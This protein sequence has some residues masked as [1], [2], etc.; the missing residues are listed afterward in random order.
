[1]IIEYGI[2]TVGKSHIK[3]GTCCQDAHYIL[4]L[5]NGWVIAAVADGVGSEKNSD[6]GSRIA[7][8]TVVKFCEECMPWDYNVINIKSMIRTAY[9]YAFKQILKEAEQSGET[10]E[11]YDTTLSLVIYDGQRIVYGHSG[12]GAILGL[13]TSGEYIAITRPQ[14]SVDGFSVIPLRAGYEQWVIDSYDEDLVAV[15]L[16]TDGML[17]TLCN[18][19]LFDHEREIERAY[20]PLVSYFA[21]PNGFADNSVERNREEITSFVVADEQYNSLDFYNR[22]LKIYKKHLPEKAETI[23]NSFKKNNYPVGMMQLQQDDKTIVGLINTELSF[24]DKD[25]AYYSEPD[26]SGLQEAW[27][28][29]AYPH[30]YVKS[31]IERG[32]DADNNTIG[33][34]ETIAI[35]VV[36]SNVV[37]ESDDDEKEVG[38]DDI[39]DV[40]VQTEMQKIISSENKSV[41]G[42][43]NELSTSESS[44]QVC[45]EQRKSKKKRFL[46][47]MDNLLS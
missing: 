22:L 19:L 4:K 1:M 37:N 14:K 46:E 41:K 2:S 33:D 12:D 30:L 23:V 16:M 15:L 18:P 6:I 20:V 45:T 9:N 25:E 28:R 39:L 11:S 34:D 38:A 40:E 26:W 10:I 3:S 32:T 35:D 43:K 27:N 31:T 44:T 21:D 8:E 42:D 13:T 24:E 47:V 5:Q 7:A 36:D 29:M 17:E